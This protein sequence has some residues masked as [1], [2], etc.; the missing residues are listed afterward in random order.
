MNEIIEKIQLII[1]EDYIIKNRFMQNE[2]LYR[3]MKTEKWAVYFILTFIFI[4]AAFN[5]IGSIAMLVID[6][7][8]EKHDLE[9]NEFGN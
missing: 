7:K 6:K 4:I 5:M 8:K 1:G 9:E 3:V 2:F